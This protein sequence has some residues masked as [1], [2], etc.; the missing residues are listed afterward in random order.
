VFPGLHLE[1][2]AG[3]AAHSASHSQC[4][5][6]MREA[7]REAFNAGCPV[8]LVV[9]RK[10]TTDV[11]QWRFFCRLGDLTI[12]PHQDALMETTVMEALGILLNDDFP[13]VDTS[14]QWGEQG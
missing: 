2:K 6:W 11:G 5:R 1:V 12:N 10:G 7:E 8:F 4:E 13:G 9:K 3:N 14:N